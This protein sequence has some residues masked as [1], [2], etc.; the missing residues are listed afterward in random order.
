MLQ[1]DGSCMLSDL[2]GE[3][4]ELNLTQDII[5]KTLRSQE[6][7][8]VISNMKLTSRDKLLAF[9]IDSANNSVYASLRDDEV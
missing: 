6:G 8:H 3:P 4:I 2:E 7:N 1:E 9:T 5:V